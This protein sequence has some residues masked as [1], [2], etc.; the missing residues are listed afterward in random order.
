MGVATDSRHTFVALLVLLISCPAFS[1]GTST[2]YTDS[3]GRAIV[4]PLGDTSFAD[5]VTSFTLGM[6]APRDKR[7]ADPGTTLGPPDYNPKRID[8]ANPQDVVLG[9]GGVLVVRFADNAVVDVAGPDLYVFEV[10]PAIE[11]MH[12]AISA[13]GRTWI[14]VADITGGTAEIDIARVATTGTRYQYARVTDLKKG[15]GGQY[16][17]ADIDAIG[18]IGAAVTIAFDASVLFEFGKSE[19]LPQAQAAL[20]DAASRI[21]TF[22]GAAVTVEG[23]TDNVGAADYNARLSQAR[24]EA[25]RTFLV[26]RPELQGR[27]ITARGFGATRP[28]AGNATE[29]DRQKNRRVEIVISSA[30]PTTYA[31]TPPGNTTTQGKLPT[32]VA[33]SLK[34]LDDTC[35]EVGGKPLNSD[36][37]K[38]VDLNADGKGDFVV[39]V[40]SAKCDG[41][42]SIYGDREKGV[43]VYV[44][45]GMGGATET[46]SDSVYGVT[47]EGDGLAAKLWATVSAQRCGKEPAADFATENF[48]YRALVWNAQTKQFQYAPVSTVR[49]LQ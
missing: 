42:A 4:F 21:A 43:A 26:T 9:C 29:G 11:P 41:A 18:A 6:P 36:V 38:R 28:A 5:E 25:V 8:P 2:T 13:D 39:D 20:L 12:L 32:V 47:I 19:L 48:C 3:R 33:A 45:D 44:G 14:E 31:A 1:E 24:A 37:V 40:G 49:M 17:G 46:F 22:K 34:S 35:R 23:H 27:A 15:C 7:W 30:S 16:P 10:G